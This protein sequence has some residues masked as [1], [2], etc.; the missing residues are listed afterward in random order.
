MMEKYL[1]FV[2]GGGGARGAMQVGAIR[3][4]FEAG[5]QPDLLLGTSIGAANATALAL[6]GVNLGGIAALEQV[7]QSVVESQLMDSPGR[8]VWHMLSGRPFH[9]SKRAR[10]FIIASGIAPDLS[11]DQIHNVRLGLVGAELSS[12]RTLIYGMEPGQSILEGVLASCSVPPW[13]S[14]IKNE[15]QLIVDGGA[16]SNLPIEPALYMGATEIIAFDLRIP[17][18]SYGSGNYLSQ[19]EMSI[20]AITERE[21]YLETALAEAKGV[22]VHFLRLQ[23]N[24]P[25]QMWDFSAYRKLI[26]VGYETAS[27][28]LSDWNR[29]RSEPAYLAPIYER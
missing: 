15:D 27:R 21:I 5:Y 16:L 19:V 24:P 20:N 10:G 12:G 2:L 25:I 1:A 13:F 29:I 9:T 26:D 8:L 22:P 23:C 6:F 4:L 18:S 11:F 14:P 17:L 3:A 28:Y 7:Y